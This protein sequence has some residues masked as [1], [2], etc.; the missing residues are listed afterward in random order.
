MIGR[1]RTYGYH[2]CTLCYL[3]LSLVD[4]VSYPA[5]VDYQQRMILCLIV[6]ITRRVVEIA[7]FR[8]EKIGKMYRRLLDQPRRNCRLVDV[9]MFRY[10]EVMKMYCSIAI[11]ISR[12]YNR[13]LLRLTVNSEIGCYLAWLCFFKRSEAGG[14]LILSKISRSYCAVKIAIGIR[15][16]NNKARTCPSTNEIHTYLKVL[17]ILYYAMIRFDKDSIL[18]LLNF[19]M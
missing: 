13:S 1:S 2:I 5:T 19:G 14:S 11:I 9:P 16:M 7:N 4:I 18:V 6:N 10:F 3:L 15:K 17:T 8:R 12:V